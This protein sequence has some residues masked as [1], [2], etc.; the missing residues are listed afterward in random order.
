[1]VECDVA[2]VSI[3]QLGQEK[4]GQVLSDDRSTVL[5]DTYGGVMWVPVKLTV[6]AKTTTDRERIT[7]LASIYIR[8]MARNLFA[9]NNIEYLDIQ[10]GD[11][12]EEEVNGITT[13]VGTVTVK[14]QAEFK[15]DV[16]MRI[17]QEVLSINLNDIKF[18]VGSG[19]P[20]PD[21][22]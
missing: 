6:Y 19:T 13:F 5:F 16:D 17:Y 14:C 10:A 3:Q 11:A 8:F 22:G 15:Q 9:L 21:A 7:D 2:N 1:M 12:G 20:E 4:I 18:A